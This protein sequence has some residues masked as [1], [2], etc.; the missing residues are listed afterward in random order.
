MEVPPKE[1]GVA[2]RIFWQK[3]GDPCRFRL[4]RHSQLFETC[5][6]V[7]MDIFQLAIMQPVA[8]LIRIAALQWS[9]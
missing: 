1:S 4:S 7:L 2:V 5:F 8:V 6:S 3:P 9:F